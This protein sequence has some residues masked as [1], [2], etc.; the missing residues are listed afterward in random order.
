MWVLGVLTL[1]VTQAQ[2]IGSS[3]WAQ[4]D[5]KDGD[6]DVAYANTQA[7]ILGVF[8]LLEIITLLLIFFFVPET[9][10]S[11]IGRS[12]DSLI[13]LSLEELNYIFEV[14]TFLHSTYQLKVMLPW[15]FRKGKWLLFHWFTQA[16]NPDDP[17]ILYRWA[18]H[19]I[20]DESSENGEERSSDGWVQQDM[21]V[22][23]PLNL[24]TESLVDSFA[25]ERRYY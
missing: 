6:S 20:E 4:H 2:F 11:T 18:E 23:P 8:V 19:Q 5:S 24:P 14:P 16:D 17:E 9:S 13:W 21:R 15:V 10:G 12:D 1:C 7:I 3:S 22:L 25:R